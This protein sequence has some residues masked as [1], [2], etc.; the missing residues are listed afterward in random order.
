[1]GIDPDALRAQCEAKLHEL[2]IPRPFCLRAFCDAVARHQQHPVLL[3]PIRTGAALCGLWMP[4]PDGDLIFYEENTSPLHQTHIILHEIAHLL[5]GHQPTSVADIA[6][7][8]SLLPHVS[9]E[10]LRHILQRTTY[11]V[12]DEREAELLASLVLA[13]TMP[14]ERRQRPPAEGTAQLLRRLAS[15]LEDASGEQP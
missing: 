8:R 1:M 7:L 15:A 4:T 3:R 10:T 9:P 11:S 13:R 12:K 6:A 2:E 5:F 14:L